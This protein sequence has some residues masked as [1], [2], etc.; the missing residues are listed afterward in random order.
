MHLPSPWC[1]IKQ[2]RVADAV[3]WDLKAA[4]TAGATIAHTHNALI[5]SF[6]VLFQLRLLLVLEARVN[7]LI[8]DDR[9]LHFRGG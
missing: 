1:C 3:G 2:R 6:P 9:E 4:A 7:H 8:V 5:V